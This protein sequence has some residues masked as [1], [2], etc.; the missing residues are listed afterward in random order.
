MSESIATDAAE[1]TNWTVD[2]ADTDPIE[3]RD[4]VAEALAVLDPGVPFVVTYADAVKAVGHSCPTA[5]GAFRIAQVGLDALYPDEYPVR[6]DIEVLA[7][8]PKEDATY[9]VMSRLISYVTGA[10]EADGFG[11][12]AGG[13]GDRKQRLSFGDFGADEPTF[14]FRRRDTGGIVEVTYHV[15]NIPEAGAATQYLP[16]LIDGEASDDEREAFREAW[17]DRVRSV[18]T[19]DDLF[20]VWE[21]D[22]EF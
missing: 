22:K 12:L 18:L 19:D 7:G 10:S 13:H 14:A 3:I 1:R 15:G 9:G 16:K 4:P 21:T 20:T 11:G 17:H 5:A 6:G 2:Y 8:G